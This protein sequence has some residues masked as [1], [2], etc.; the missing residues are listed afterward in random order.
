MLKLKVALDPGAIVAEG[1]EFQTDPPHADEGQGTRVRPYGVEFFHVVFPVFFIVI[2]TGKDAPLTTDSGATNE[3][4]EAPSTELSVAVMF[5]QAP[6][7]L[8][9]FDSD[10]TPPPAAEVLSAQTRIEYVP[11]E[12]NV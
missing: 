2:A 11:A 7:L 12:E 1:K 3:E 5:V 6:Q 8:F 4:Q 10:I 9:S